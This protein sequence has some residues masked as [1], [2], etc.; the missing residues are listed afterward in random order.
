[1]PQVS[2]FQCR[3]QWKLR[4]SPIA[5]AN[6]LNDVSDAFQ[7]VLSFV[8]LDTIEYPK[9][10]DKNSSIPTLINVFAPGEKAQMTTLKD[11]TMNALISIM[12][13]R[14]WFLKPNDMDLGYNTTPA[15][16]PMRLF[17]SRFYVHLLLHCF[18]DSII[19]H[20]NS[21]KLSDLM[22]SKKDLSLDVLMLMRGQS[23]VV[24]KDPRYSP[25][26]EYHQHRGH[27]PLRSSYC[28]QV[29]SS[30]SGEAKEDPLA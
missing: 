7:I 21:D 12:L 19:P 30:Q 3:V 5:T 13:T 16:S 24:Q 2:L 10:L 26:C 11:S 4:R 22:S 15:E 20:W 17:R 25:A 14:G 1:M 8:Y 9:D 23:G 29:P 6:L 28:Y 27:L 18:E